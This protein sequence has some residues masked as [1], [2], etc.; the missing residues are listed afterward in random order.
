MK[1]REKALK[2]AA[3]QK[4]KNQEYQAGQLAERR[5]RAL[6]VFEKRFG[7]RPE[8]GIS[9]GQYYWSNQG[10]LILDNQIRLQFIEGHNS[11]HF[12]YMAP[13][14]DCGE[15]VRGGPA[16]TLEQLGAAIENPTCYEHDHMGGRCPAKV[17]AP[18]WQ[19]RL[20]EALGE[21]LQA[22]GFIGG[23]F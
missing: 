12:E 20:I 22:H 21:G 10:Y 8:H 6:K 4:A 18:Q 7:Y 23:E 9:E 11:P 17:E 15:I 2:A 5:E 13:C 16:Y 3:E 19:E 1:L 14:P